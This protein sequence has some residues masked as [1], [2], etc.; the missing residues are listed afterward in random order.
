MAVEDLLTTAQLPASVRD[1]A[2]PERLPLLITAASLALAEYIGYP[3]QRR[4]GIAEAV[5]SQGGAYLWLSAGAVRQVTR[6]EV[7]GAE[8]PPDAYALESP[9]MGRL[10]ARGRRWPFTGTWT[11]GVSP[12]PLAAEATGEV[13]VTYDAGWVTPGQAALDASLAVD[14]PAHV[15]L[16]AQLVATAMIQRDGAEDDVVSESIGDTSLTR[17][18]GEDG[19]VAALP[20]RA[21]Q[22]VAQYVRPRAGA[23]S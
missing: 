11:T 12:T 8:V 3:L 1:T 20:A 10:A 4:T 13:V 23:A 16:A 21:R 17:T 5:T 15:A 9:R 18:T 19:Q 22:L 7:R 6:V 2:D 14:L